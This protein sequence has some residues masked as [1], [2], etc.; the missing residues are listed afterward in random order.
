MPATIDQNGLTIETL[1]DII[2]DLT[3]GMESIYGTNINVDPNSPDGQL[4]NLIAQAKVDVEELLAQV[5]ASMDP[6]QAIGVV[7]DQRCAING[8]IRDPGTFTLQEVSITV[9]RAITLPG[10]DTS[11][12]APFTVADSNGNQYQLVTQQIIT[13]AG[14]YSMLFEAA[15]IGA[16][17]STENTISTVVTLLL[18]VTGAN[19]PLGPTTVGTNEETD[20]ALRI[21]R[22]NSVSLPSK[23]FLDGL[24]GA[25]QDVAGVNQAMVFENKTSDDPDTNGIPA[26]GIWCI[27]AGGSNADVANAIY[28]KRTFGCNMKGSIDVPITQING[29]TFD[30]LFDRPTP[31]PLYITLNVV[32]ITG[33]IDPEY[34]RTQILAQLSYAI[35]QTADASAIVALVKNIA[36]NASVSA[37]GVSSDGIT[38][39]PTLAPQT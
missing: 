5:Y 24:I 38:Y 14:T 2:A 22:A 36:P 30:V 31:E 19:N 11:P 18:G 39:T 34:I 10:L 33:I 35:N 16:I 26:H 20:A 32:A 37:E 1:T 25:L 28:V 6:D 29:S 4:I 8:V 21:R 17:S 23:G 7:L 27:V 15:T 3:A 13:V 12:T 9:D